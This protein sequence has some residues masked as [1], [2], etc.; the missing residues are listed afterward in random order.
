MP[1]CADIEF[2]PNEKGKGTFHELSLL[3]TGNNFRNL[4]SREILERNK[5]SYL[6]VNLAAYS[7]DLKQVK[8]IG[9][10]E[11]TFRFAGSSHV[12][13]E[14]FYVPEITSNIVNLG[15]Q[16]MCNNKINLLLDRNLLAVRGELIPI[17]NGL[18]KKTINEIHKIPILDGDLS[19]EMPEKPSLPGMQLGQHGS[20]E[21]CAQRFNCE[22]EE[23]T[24]IYPGGTIIS[25]TLAGADV[26]KLWYISPANSKQVTGNNIM[27]L[28]GVYQPK[29][30]GTC[31]VN[32]VSTATKRI[33]LLKGVKVGQGFELEPVQACNKDMIGEI[34]YKKLPASTVLKRIRFI[35]EKLQLDNNEMIKDRPDIK[36]KLIKVALDHFD[37]F[38]VNDT[39]IGNCDLFKYD[40]ELTEDAKPCKSKNISLNPEYEERMKEQ[41]EIW[42]A[43]NSE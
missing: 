20:G 11:L 22:M 10:V 40:I 41:L 37:I 18:T 7:V 32:V 5:I 38:S 14:I 42:L 4:I 1:I 27:L 28:E 2:N 43:S 19:Q 30:D 33:T 16:F 6:P 23:K 34:N 36:S 13:T 21:L 3:D 31:L 24:D 35:K 25:V 9:K 17:N 39:D 8:I 15:S 29:A 12:F 26:N